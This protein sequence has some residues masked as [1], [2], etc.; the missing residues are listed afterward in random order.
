MIILKQIIEKKLELYNEFMLNRQY[1]RGIWQFYCCVNISTAVL[2]FAKASYDDELFDK[3][4][5]VWKRWLSS[6]GKFDSRK[7]KLMQKYIQEDMKI[8]IL[9]LSLV[10]KINSEKQF[11]LSQFDPPGSSY[12]GCIAYEFPE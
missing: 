8:I 2:R 12:V 10:E 6:D 9:A 1:L 4:D 5:I 11:E 3:R 7:F